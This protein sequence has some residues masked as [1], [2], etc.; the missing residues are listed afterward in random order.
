MTR[1]LWQDCKF[2]KILSQTKDKPGWRRG[3]VGVNSGPVPSNTC[4]TLKGMGEH[5]R[6]R[7]RGLNANT[8]PNIRALWKV[9]S[10]TNCWPYVFF[11]L[12]F[13][14]KPQHRGA[15]IY[16]SLM[17]LWKDKLHR[18]KWR[19]QGSGSAKALWLVLMGWISLFWL[20]G[21][22][23]VW[24]LDL[25]ALISVDLNKYHTA[26]I[27]LKKVT[28]SIFSYGCISE[29]LGSWNSRGFIQHK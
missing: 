2:S 17:A 22:W 6:W 7:M 18:M 9:N 26:H 1:S 8:S 10:S 19:T 16:G 27:I 28:F 29:S 12:A 3:S 23:W 11:W 4:K 14:I 21:L 24:E 15:V 5:E 13:K 20:F 25:L